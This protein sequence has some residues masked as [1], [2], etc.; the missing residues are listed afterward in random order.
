MTGA[1]ASMLRAIQAMI[2]GGLIFWVIVN[3]RSIASLKKR[4]NSIETKTDA[5]YEVCFPPIKDRNRDRDGGGI[6]A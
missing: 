6:C 5:V 2:N 3:G 1:T 4:V